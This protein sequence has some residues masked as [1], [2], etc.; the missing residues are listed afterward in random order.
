MYKDCSIRYSTHPHLTEELFF[1]FEVLTRNMNELKL[2]SKFLR[3]LS[4]I[5][6]EFRCLLILPKDQTR[7]SS[8]IRFLRLSE[9]VHQT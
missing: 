7:T 2:T 9:S 5:M 3:K 8:I 4:E 1:L 6:L